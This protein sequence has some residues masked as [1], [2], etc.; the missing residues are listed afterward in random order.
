MK[1]YAITIGLE[2]HVQLK[3]KSKMFCTNSAD[4]F[5]ATPNSH[6]CP[7]CLG[8]PGALPVT[9]QEAIESAIKVGLA[10]NCEINEKTKFDRKSYFYPDLSKGYQISQYDQPIAQG[11][12]IIINKNKIRINRAHMEE[13]TGKLIHVEVKGRKVSLIDFNRC[14]VPLLEIVSEPDITSPQEARRYAKKIH[15]IMRYLEVADVDMEKAG[16][17]FDANISVKPKGEEKLGTKV[18]VKNINSFRFLEKALIFEASRQ[19]KLLEEGEKIVQETRGWVESKGETTSQRI[20]ETSPDYRYFPEPDLPPLV[21]S[22]K[23]I[24][25]LQK[26]IPELPDEKK[27]RFK[28]DYRLSDSDSTTLVETKGIANFFEIALTEYS[29]IKQVEKETPKDHQKAKQLTN[30][31]VGELSSLMKENKQNI[32]EIKIEPAGLV[33]LLVILDRGEVTHQTAKEVFVKMYRTGELPAKIISE[34]NLGQISSQEDLSEIVKD[35]IL[36]NKGAVEDLK[37]G[38]EQ[39]VRFLM[40]QVMRKTKGQAQPRIVEKIIKENLK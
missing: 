18:E 26:E 27:E 31:I 15:Q 7:V 39:A 30:W 35:V 4:Y 12:F 16:M 22:K 5:G 1:E 29:K 6:T 32:N 24:E 36:E 10:L 2:V 17:R 14:G 20:K 19:I 3:T 23:L 25:K 28:K 13:D 8:L 38:K 9:N 21:I 33:E 40:G 11:G 34:E 37:K